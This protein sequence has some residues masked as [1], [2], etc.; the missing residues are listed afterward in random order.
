MIRELWSNNWVAVREVIE[1]DRGVKGYSYLF[2]KS[3]DGLKVVLLPYKINSDGSLR[4]MLRNEVTPCWG[5]KQ[6]VSSITGGVEKGD[7][8]GTAVLE[9]KEEAGYECELNELVNLGTTYG[10]K[11]TDTIYHLFAVDVTG[12]E[13]TKAIGDGSVLEAM[14][15]CMWG[16]DIDVI[17]CRD[18]QAAVA[19]LRLQYHLGRTILQQ[20]T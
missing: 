8:R 7:V 12:K 9:L 17:R 1:P 3:C 13:R 4:Y 2:E 15:E 16:K 5:M 18:P 19:Y 20:K 10:T 6:V 14:A 11:S